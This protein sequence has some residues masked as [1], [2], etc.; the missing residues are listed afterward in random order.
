MVE[1]RRMV[2]SAQ[3]LTT[4]ESQL[5]DR[6]ERYYAIKLDVFRRL[7][8]DG[9]SDL[10]VISS[11]AGPFA[12]RFGHLH[13]GLE[14]AVEA[15]MTPRDAIDAA[16]RIAAEACG[17]GSQVGTLETGKAADILIVE[18]DP[19]DDIRRVAAP[20]AVYR[21]GQRVFAYPGETLMSQLAVE[22]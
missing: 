4:A 8:E 1:L 15:G 5:R 17:V 3:P 14:L 2:A 11:D 10:L 20:L 6:L 16:T 21:D 18:G 22:S 9:L 13:Y 7:M 12:A 19:L